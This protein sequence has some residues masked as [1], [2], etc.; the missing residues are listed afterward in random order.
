M[1]S[2]NLD[3]DVWQAAACRS[4]GRNLTPEEWAEYIGADEPYRATCDPWPAA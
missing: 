2:W 1:T 3:P 4:A